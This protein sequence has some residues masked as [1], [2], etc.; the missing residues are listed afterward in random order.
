MK[1]SKLIKEIRQIAR[2]CGWA[3]GVHGSL[4]RDIDLIGVPWIQ[5][6]CEWPELLAKLREKIGKELGNI[7]NMPHCRIGF[8]LVDKKAKYIKGSEKRKGEWKP[9]AIDLSL[10]DPR[11]K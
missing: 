10:V 8:L 1:T 5:T 7:S 3:I 2:D 6:A 9:K 11:I 4:K